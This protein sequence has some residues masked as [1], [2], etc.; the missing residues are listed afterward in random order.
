MP[1]RPSWRPL[2]TPLHKLRVVTWKEAVTDGSLMRG[3]SCA[4]EGLRYKHAAS[5]PRHRVTGTRRVGSRTVVR[6]SV[7]ASGARERPAQEAHIHMNAPH[8]RE[9]RA[10]TRAGNTRKEETYRQEYPCLPAP[11]CEGQVQ[12]RRGMES[13]HRSTPAPTERMQRMRGI[14][15]LPASAPEDDPR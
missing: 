1:Q 2:S 4:E 10:R 12:A 3:P 14:G 6:G 8:I 7:E 9:A 15:R 5:L 13:R 11:G